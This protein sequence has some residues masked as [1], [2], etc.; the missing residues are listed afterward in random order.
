[1][2]GSDGKLYTEFTKLISKFC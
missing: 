1:L 2:F